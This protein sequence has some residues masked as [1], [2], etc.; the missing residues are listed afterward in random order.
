MI[1]G[2]MGN[3]LFSNESQITFASFCAV[4]QSCVV[5]CLRIKCVL[6]FRKVL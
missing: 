1:T 6:D 5:V 4:F 2:G 3:K